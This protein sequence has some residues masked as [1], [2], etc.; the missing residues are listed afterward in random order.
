MVQ[1]SPAT[2]T[3]D[4]RPVAGAMG[5]E[6]HGKKE[7]DRFNFGGVSNEAD[8]RRLADLEIGQSDFLDKKIA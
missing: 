1:S 3:L 6:V 4:I 5:A 8:I 7:N 2:Q